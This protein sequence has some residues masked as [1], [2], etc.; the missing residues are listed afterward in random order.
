ML[1]FPYI[2]LSPPLSPSPHVY[3]SILYVCFSIGAL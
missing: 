2:S 1:L 3:K